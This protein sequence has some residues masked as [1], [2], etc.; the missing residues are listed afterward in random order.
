MKFLIT[1]ILIGI[2]SFAACTFFPWWSIAIVAFIVA[3]V[4]PQSA[5]SAFL[6]GFL[7]TGLLWLVLSYYISRIN[8]DLLAGKISLLIFHSNNPLLLILATGLIGALVSGLGALSGNL[9]RITRGK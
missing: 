2:L 4:I 9:F 7:S 3:L 6:A 1:F 5:F 8:N